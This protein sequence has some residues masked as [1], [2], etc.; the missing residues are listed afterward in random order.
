MPL[1]SRVAVAYARAAAMRPVDCHWPVLGLYSSVLA[2]VAKTPSPPAT[3]T[4]PSP[5]SV[6]V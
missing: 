1:P 4:M 3:R 5:S 6:A 2:R